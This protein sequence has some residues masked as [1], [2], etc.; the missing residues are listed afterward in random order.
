MAASDCTG[1]SC[2]ALGPPTR[3]TEVPAWLSDA[4][5]GSA[6]PA[7]A[8]A[9]EACGVGSCLPDDASQCADYVPPQPPDRDRADA[10][11]ASDAG[12]PPGIR[13][14]AG[15]SDAGTEEGPAIDGSFTQPTRPLPGPARFACQLT[16]DDGAVSRACGVAGSQGAEQA[17]TSSLDCAPGLGCVGPARSGRC[18]PYCC[19]VG[20]DTCGDGFYCAQR[21]LRSDALGNADGPLVPVCDRADNCNLGEDESCIGASCVCGREMACQLVRPNGTTACVKLGPNPGRAGQ[22]CPCDRGYHCSQ[23]TTPAVCVKICEL[24]AADADTCGSG[25]CQTAPPLPEKWGI[26]VGTTPEQMMP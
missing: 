9:K 3:P 22:K 26:C 19:G 24:D 8:P 2:G 25:V 18:L 1:L 13:S 23:A 6:P 7:E 20:A 5:D 11:A 10:G 4:P 21:P 14:D 15:P 12:V 17:C 16:L